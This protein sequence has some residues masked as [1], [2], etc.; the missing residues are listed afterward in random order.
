MLRDD[1]SETHCRAYA[2]SIFIDNLR[3]VCYNIVRIIEVCYNG[4]S[5]SA[6]QLTVIILINVT[7]FDLVS[8]C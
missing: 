4:N 6:S 5:L 7:E 1:K 8:K 3:T 2:L